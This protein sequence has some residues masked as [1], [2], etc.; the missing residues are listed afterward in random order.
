MADET[1]FMRMS[2]R[3]TVVLLFWTLFEVLMEGFYRAAY[4][5]LPGELGDELLRRFPSIGGRLHRLYRRTWQVSFLDDLR[6]EGF[7]EEASLIDR[8]QIARNSF[9]HGHP[10][11]IADDLVDQTLQHLEEVQ[12]GWIRIF[13]KRCTGRSNKV[14]IWASTE[15]R[16]AFVR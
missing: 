16:P 1:R 10:E 11:A 12:R 15:R 7:D 6:S 2:Q 13:N 4:A 14:P 9:I 3:F 5:D 8:V